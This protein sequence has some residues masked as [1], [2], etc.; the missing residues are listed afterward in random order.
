MVETIKTQNDNI[1]ALRIDG[2]FSEADLKPLLP[3]MKEKLTHTPKLSLFVEY[4][5]MNDFTLDTLVEVLRANFG[6][7]SGFDKAAV[8]TSKDW[9]TE[10]TKLADDT[11]GLNIKTFHFSEKPQALDWLEEA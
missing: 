8:V 10:A 6:N 4:I 11:H 1:I 2:T 3:I 9:L 5:D 7:L